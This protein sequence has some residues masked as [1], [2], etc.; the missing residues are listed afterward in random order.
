MAIP[1][2]SR[3]LPQL[4]AIAEI[5]YG[6]PFGRNGY[7]GL[8][9]AVLFV[10]GFQRVSPGRN[11]I[12]RERT[13]FSG[14]GKKRMRRNAD[15]GAHPGMD[16]AGDGKKNLFVIEGLDLVLGAG[17]LRFIPG[18]VHLAFGVNVVVHRVIVQDFKWLARHQSENVG[19]I[20]AAFLIEHGRRGRRSP[21]RFRETLADPDEDIAQCAVRVY[22][23]CFGSRG[24]AML[25]FTVGIGGHVENGHHR[26][27]SG[28]QNAASDGPRG[29][30]IHAGNGKPGLRI[31]GRLRRASTSRKTGRD[32][33]Q[34]EKNGM[35]SQRSI[36]PYGETM[37]EATL[38]DFRSVAAD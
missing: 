23:H 34:R 29:G 22:D 31:R 9:S 26:S 32:E 1:A 7:F 13:F 35:S 25:T 14:Y 6:P 21:K 19:L 2:A 28:K 12:E 3:W 17:R 16:V 38:G 18:A 5:H 11:A 27:F 37:Q 30:W 10:Y 20:R 15:P 33:G 4:F 36:F 8:F 24:R